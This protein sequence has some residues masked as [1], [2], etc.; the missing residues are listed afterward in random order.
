MTAH[1]FFLPEEQRLRMQIFFGNAVCKPSEKQLFLDINLRLGV[2]SEQYA[3]NLIGRWT[4]LKK[5]GRAI[6][7]NQETRSTGV[8]I[9]ADS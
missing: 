9:F 7:C 1:T 4:G 3:S 6:V 5:P 8:S 2:T